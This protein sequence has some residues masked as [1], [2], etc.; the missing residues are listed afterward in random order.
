MSLQIIDPT[1]VDEP[2]LPLQAVGGLARTGLRFQRM[3]GYLVPGPTQLIWI[4]VYLLS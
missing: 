3:V 1:P 2:Y 4:L